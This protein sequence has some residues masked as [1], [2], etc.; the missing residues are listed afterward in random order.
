MF[1]SK[2]LHLHLLCT[3]VHYNTLSLFIELTSDNLIIC[4]MTPGDMRLTQAPV[5]SETYHSEL[6]SH[7]TILF[8]PILNQQDSRIPPK[9]SRTVSL[10]ILATYLLVPSHAFFWSR[11]FGSDESSSSSPASPPG[12]RSGD[13]IPSWDS[14]PKAD[15]LT[16]REAQ[17]WCE[18]RGMR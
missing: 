15:S 13:L 11:L 6:V 2:Y 18:D 16:W 4:D 9:M 7:F 10:L 12:S 8:R 14:R 5:V 3:L 1:F 17:Q